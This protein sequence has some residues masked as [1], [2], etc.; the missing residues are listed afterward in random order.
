[1][2]FN[3]ITYEMTLKYHGQVFSGTYDANSRQTRFFLNGEKKIFTLNFFRERL[4]SLEL[5]DL[6]SQ[7]AQMHFFDK[8]GFL[9]RVVR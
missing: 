9:I 3:A 6:K 4:L 1:M 7:M 8:N 5:R 2:I